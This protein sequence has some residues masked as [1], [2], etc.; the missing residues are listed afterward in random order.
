ME[1]G[2]VSERRWNLDAIELIQTGGFA[3]AIGSDWK[4][5]NA[6]QSSGLPQL[7]QTHPSLGTSTQRRSAHDFRPSSAS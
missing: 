5:A 2:V 7:G 4:T 1:V 3:S 6:F